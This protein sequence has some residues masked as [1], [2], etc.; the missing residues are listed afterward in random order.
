M[1]F[2]FDSAKLDSCIL[3]KNTKVGAKAELV[4]CIT[5]AGFE[6]KPGATLK[7]EKLESS[8]WASR[9]AEDADEEDEDEDENDE[10][11][12]GKEGSDTE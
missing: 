4:R 12:M 8:D 1:F 3:G 6:I 9:A 7:N 5:Q 11:E 2:F 10:I